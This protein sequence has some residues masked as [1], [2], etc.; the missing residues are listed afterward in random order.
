MAVTS[1]KPTCFFL[2]WLM[3]A[4]AASSIQGI[5]DHRSSSHQQAEPAGAEVP[6]SG[7]LHNDRWHEATWLPCI[8]AKATGR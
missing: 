5:K 2:T 1:Q 8:Q 4:L 3:R 6:K 7:I